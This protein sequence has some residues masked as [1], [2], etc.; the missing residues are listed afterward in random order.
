MKIAD[1][2]KKTPAELNTFISEQRAELA[3]KRR[4]LHAGELQN[5][6]SIQNIRRTIATAL[7]VRTEQEAT[8]EEA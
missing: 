5:P 4:S 2:R 7:T 1:I 8:K 3:E 6:M